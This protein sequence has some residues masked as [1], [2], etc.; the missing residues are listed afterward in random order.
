MERKK[1]TYKH[2]LLV[3]MPL[4]LLMLLTENNALDVYVHAVLT[5]PNVDI[6][7]D[8]LVSRTDRNS[9]FSPCVRFDYLARWSPL[10]FID[11]PIIGQKRY[12]DENFSR[13]I[14]KEYMKQI[15]KRY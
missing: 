9:R 11:H 5:H 12:V 10:W 3:T 15:Y 7:I 2:A 6:V 8:Q 14:H 13:A 4:E 1:F